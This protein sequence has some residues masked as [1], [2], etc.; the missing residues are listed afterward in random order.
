M[1]CVLSATRIIG[2]KFI[3][4]ECGMIQLL[5][6]NLALDLDNV[7][8]IEFSPVGF[9]KMEINFKIG[10]P[11]TVYR[12][13]PAFEDLENFLQGTMEDIEIKEVEG[14]ENVHLYEVRRKNRLSGKTYAKL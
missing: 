1:V 4:E 2:E 6:Q 3:N 8:S 7:N 10:N 5:S 9:G 14:E 12:T 13:D 11:I